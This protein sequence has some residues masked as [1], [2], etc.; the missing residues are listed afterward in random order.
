MLTYLSKYWPRHTLNE[1]YKLYVRPHLDYG[2]VI[3]HSPTKVCEFSHSVILPN[4]MKRLESL[5][6]SAALGGEHHHHNPA[7]G[8]EHHERRYT[9]SLVVN[10]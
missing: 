3:Y 9:L 10:R 8:G 2:D 5:Q 6:Y 7:H 1:L 4:Q